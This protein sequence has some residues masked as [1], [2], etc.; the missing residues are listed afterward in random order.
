[1]KLIQVNLTEEQIDRADR[2][3]VLLTK[4]LQIKT[5]RSDVIRIGLDRFL[6][7]QEVSNDK[8]KSE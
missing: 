8:P 6:K 7:E 4:E 5:T 3:A 2:L 1:M